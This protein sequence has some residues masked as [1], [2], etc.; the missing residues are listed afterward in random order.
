MIKKNILNDIFREKKPTH[1]EDEINV[2]GTEQSYT[3]G[4][5][6]NLER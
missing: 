3:M 4:I 1:E 2:H 6:Q 5:Y